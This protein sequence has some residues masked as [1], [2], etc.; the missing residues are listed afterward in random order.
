MRIQSFSGGPLLVLALFSLGVRGYLMDYCHN[1]VYTQEKC[2]LE[3]QCKTSKDIENNA[4]NGSHWTGIELNK[5][6]AKYVAEGTKDEDIDKAPKLIY[7]RGWTELWQ[8]PVRQIDEKVDGDFCHED[9]N[10]C[11]PDWKALEEVN[12]P[13]FECRKGDEGGF[14][15]PFD[16]GV[17][18][19]KDGDLVCK[20]D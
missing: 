7:F 8:K 11:Y 10:A 15:L 16:A 13:S 5:C 20:D 6:L 19:N 1:Y 3:A 17:T 9:R 14:I 4:I 18:V 12:D 2:L